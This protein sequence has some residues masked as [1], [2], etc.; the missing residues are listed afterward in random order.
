M[1]SR[2]ALPW[3]LP[4]AFL[5]VGIGLFAPSKKSTQLRHVFI[6]QT[7]EHQFDESIQGSILASYQRTQVQNAVVIS[8]KFDDQ[9]FEKVATDLFSKLQLGKFNKGR[10]IL[11]LFSPKNQKLKIEV[12]YALEGTLPDVMVHYFERAAKAMTYSGHYE[13]FWAELINT[14]NIEIYEKEKGDKTTAGQAYDFNQSKFLSGGAGIAKS[15]YANGIDQLEREILPRIQTDTRESSKALSLL[16]SLNV[17]LESLRTGSDQNN[18]WILSTD[19]KVYREIRPTTSFQLY[20]NWRMYEAAKFE[21][22]VQDQFLALAVYS[23]KPV[24]PIVFIKEKDRWKVH[25]PLS[26]SLF[27][28]FEDSMQ[29]F[30]KFP[31]ATANPEM[32]S[33][34]AKNFNRPI[35]ELPRLTTEYLTREALKE[36]HLHYLFYRLNW[37]DQVVPLLETPSG[38]ETKNLYIAWDAYQNLGRYSQV[39]R[40]LEALQKAKPEN[41]QLKATLDFY[42]RTFD[43]SGP[44]WVLSL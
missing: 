3:I 13:D 29:V 24:L 36:S 28:R 8:D 17:Y 21:G 15:D 18:H 32:D 31:L 11:Y 6:N 27:Q 7:Q 2:K 26:W 16:E 12:G 39:I 44:Q 38:R 42:R 20:R 4:V 34:L 23:G 1:L 35:Y 19:S 14:L 33:F 40:T 10:A 43:F 30:L 5:G 22:L 41:S 9:D 25:E 37:L